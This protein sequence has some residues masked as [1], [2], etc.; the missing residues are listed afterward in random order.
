MLVLHPLGHL[1]SYL[2]LVPFVKSPEGKLPVDLFHGEKDVGVRLF[3]EEAVVA[4]SERVGIDYEKLS[5]L[6]GVV[7]ADVNHGRGDV[8][9][10]FNVMGDM[11]SLSVLLGSVWSA[12][13]DIEKCL[14]ESLYTGGLLNKD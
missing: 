6:I 1:R 14:D 3:S 5:V 11:E 8:R 13:V 7:S 10:P 4:G 9:G 12:D 2:L